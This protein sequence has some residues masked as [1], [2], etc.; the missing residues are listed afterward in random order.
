MA[1]K[2][3]SL[4]CLFWMALIL[5]VLV[6]F[7]F[8]RSRIMN[9]LEETGFSTYLYREKPEEP[10]VR[11]VS[12]D[13]EEQTRPEEKGVSVKPEEETPEEG[14]PQESPPVEISVDIR[15]E[16][17]KPPKEET[18]PLI[19]KRMRKSAV[20]FVEVSEEGSISLKQIIRPVY[21]ED[22]PL[23]ETLQVLLEGL[24]AEELNQ[25]LISLIPKETQLKRVWIRDGVAYLDFTEA[26]RFN[27]FGTEGLKAELQQIVFTATEFQTV[28]AVQILINGEKTDYL[29]TEGIYVGEPLSRDDVL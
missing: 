12:P 9:V 24:T 16:E 19:E 6:V 20:Y 11:R 28:S 15:S 27:Q 23:T 2:K 8:N 18:D 10:D 13:E 25:G 3:T 14:T 7:F 21:Y 17:D 22:S 26:L 29:S 4:G 1:K 5:L